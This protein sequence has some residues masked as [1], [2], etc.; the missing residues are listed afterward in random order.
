MIARELYRIFR[1]RP[2]VDLKILRFFTS[3]RRNPPRLSME[4]RSAFDLGPF[5]CYSLT[6]EI[7]PPDNGTPMIGYTLKASAPISSGMDTEISKEGLTRQNSHPPQKP[8][9]RS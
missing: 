2:T 3:S 1:P 6:A 8:A 5:L 7:E 9:L 4:N